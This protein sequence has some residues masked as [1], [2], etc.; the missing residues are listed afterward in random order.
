MTFKEWKKWMRSLPWLLKWFVVLI[1]F[2]PVIDNFYYLKEVS[3]FLSPLNIVGI[4]T[5]VLCIAAIIKWRN[6]SN[7]PIDFYFKIWTALAFFSIIFL[8]IYDPVS[9]LFYEYL[10][11]LTLPIYIFFFVRLLIRSKED[12]HGVLQTFIYSAIFVLAIFLY[13][14]VI[15][16]VRVVESRGLS[17]IQGYYGD[18][19]N[20]SIYLTQSFLIICYFYFTQNKTVSSV[21]RIRK[22][23]I[24][25]FVCI[26]ML[27]NIHHS[28]SYFVFTFLFVLFLSFNFRENTNNSIF[29]TMVLIATFYFFGQDIIEEKIS[30]LFQTDI[31]VYEGEKENDRLLHGRV[32]RW[33]MMWEDFSNAPIAAQF[34]GIPLK[35]DYPYYHIS[36]NAH[37][38]FFRILLFTGFTGLTVYLLILFNLYKRMRLLNRPQKFLMMGGMI[39]LILYSVST[40]PTLY[41]S[42]LYV[43]YSIFA[44]V[45]L[46]VNLIS[47]K[48]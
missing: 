45:S 28:A 10:I 35:L 47:A 4:L 38:D 33:K 43:I 32:G 18:V 40:T 8:F 11:R 37:N 25:S 42:V 22:V 48:E 6:S 2:R 29:I 19:L 46:P 9:L 14:I 30:P 3:P 21:K 34:F 44:F 24:V 16:P 20:Y 5:P 41:P 1:L 39:I 31:A 26:L 7:T 36:S 27:F 12:L 13:E 17:R 15:N 23:I